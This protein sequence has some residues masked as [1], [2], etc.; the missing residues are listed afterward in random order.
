MCFVKHVI[1]W[2]GVHQQK[3]RQKPFQSPC[4]VRSQYVCGWSWGSTGFVIFIYS[5]I[6]IVWKWNS[7]RLWTKVHFVIMLLEN[8]NLKEIHEQ[9]CYYLEQLF[10]C[11]KVSLCPSEPAGK[12]Y[13]LFLHG[14]SLELLRL[15]SGYDLS[16]PNWNSQQGH[17]LPFSAYNCVWGSYAKMSL[18][19]APSCGLLIPIMPSLRPS[20]VLDSHISNLNLWVCFFF[21]L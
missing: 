19:M 21:S 6:F 9:L 3:Y 1:S 5:F 11:E 17:V 18:N 10:W 12:S 2:D 7:V 4:K 13:N 15:T 16:P 14:K 20:V 8:K